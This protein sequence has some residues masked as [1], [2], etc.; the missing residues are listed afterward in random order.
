[1]T[2]GTGYIEGG[3][4]GKEVGMMLWDNLE[5]WMVGVL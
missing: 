3:V 4:R 1:M 2:L 5:W